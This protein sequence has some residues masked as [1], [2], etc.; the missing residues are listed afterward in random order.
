MPQAPQWAASFFTSAQ[1]APQSVC[2]AVH[3]GTPASSIDGGFELHAASK[4]AAATA[5]D[6]KRGSERL[7]DA[8]L[9]LHRLLRRRVE[10]LLA[11]HAGHDDLT[12]HQAPRLGA[13]GQ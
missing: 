7:H 12:G 10:Q 4:A 5:S 9:D 3:S 13:R 1:V 8:D 6:R 11:E 2:A